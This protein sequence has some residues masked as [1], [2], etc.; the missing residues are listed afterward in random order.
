M[1]T[2]KIIFNNNE[3]ASYAITSFVFFYIGYEVEINSNT[4]IISAV[5]YDFENSIVKLTVIQ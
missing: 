5:K 4:Y 3:I 1:N 2:V